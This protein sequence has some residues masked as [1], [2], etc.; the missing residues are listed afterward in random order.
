M[1]QI[2]QHKDYGQVDPG[3]DLAKPEAGTRKFTQGNF[4]VKVE[5]TFQL[6]GRCQDRTL[7]R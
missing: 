7:L 4:Y 5:V 2:L 3:L 6:P 1:A